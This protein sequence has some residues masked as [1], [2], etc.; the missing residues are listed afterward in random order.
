MSAAHDERSGSAGPFDLEEARLVLERTPAVLEAWLVGLPDAW[1]DAREAPEAWSAREVVG[2]LIHGERTDWLART[3]SILERGEQ[4]VFEPF[5]RFAHLSEP[6]RGARE[7]VASFGLLRAA[8]LVE[9]ERLRLGAADLGRRGTHPALGTVTLRQ[10]LATWVV[11]DLGHLAQIAR[12][13]SAR[14]AAEVGPW[15]AYLPVLGRAGAR[16]S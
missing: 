9:L 14:Y 6:R 8:N 12:A 7:L 16:G 2:H 1:L 10:L 3:R 15:L 4:G 11:H 13:L 5:D